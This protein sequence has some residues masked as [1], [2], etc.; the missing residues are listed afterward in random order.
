M[1]VFP[2]MNTSLTT[3]SAEK[4]VPFRSNAQRNAFSDMYCLFPE[5]FQSILE[6]FQS[7]F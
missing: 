6:I 2:A 1:L 5:R 7:F 3:F 4:D